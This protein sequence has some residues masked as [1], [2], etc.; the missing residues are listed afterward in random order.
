[1]TDVIVLNGGSS[2]GKS[3]I[4]RLLQELLDAPWA[5][6]GVDDLAAA[7]A[8][9]LV[10]EAPPR[11]GRPSLLAF[12]ADGTVEVGEAWR[13]VEKAWHAGVAAMARSG[14]GVILDEV[15]LGGGAGQRRIAEALSGLSVLWVG[16]HCSPAVAAEREKGRPDRI[17]GMASSQAMTVHEAVRYDVVVDTTATSSDECA[18]TVLAHVQQ[19]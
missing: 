13:P 19:R 5:A 16:V 12:G 2:S 3:S 15:L 8:P 7:L 10:G 4:A 17:V 1:M 6:L 14:L 11:P 18:R 9:S